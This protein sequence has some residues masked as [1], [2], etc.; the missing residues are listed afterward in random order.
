[1]RG[2]YST[3]T[4]DFSEQGF[5]VESFE[6]IYGVDV[7]HVAAD[8]GY[9]LRNLYKHLNKDGILVISETICPFESRCMH[10]EIISNLHDNYYRVQLD[11]EMRPTRGFL[12]KDICMRNFEKACFSNVDSIT[13][14]NRYDQLASL[15]SRCTHLWY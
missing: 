8:L 6:S 13:E 15:S 9:S 5:Q 11:P 7:L 3:L 1:M 2:K 12:T 14:L 10:H 4:R